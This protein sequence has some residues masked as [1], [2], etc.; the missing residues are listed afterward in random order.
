MIQGDS[1][2]AGIRQRR[3]ELQAV[4]RAALQGAE[5]EQI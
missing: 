4:L 5:E 3:D 2:A 1:G